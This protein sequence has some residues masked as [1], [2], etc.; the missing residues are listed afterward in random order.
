[1]DL[2]AAMSTGH[3]GSM[4]TTHANAPNEALVRLETLSMMGDTQVPV[5]AIRRQIATAVHLV[6]QI[7]RM[8]DGSRK[9]THI[10]EV[11]PELDEQGRYIVKDIYRFVQRGRT[12]EGRIV[13][14]MVPTGYIPSFMQ[15]IEINRLPFARDKFTP[16]EW[17]I[18]LMMKN[19]EAAA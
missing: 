6:V 3:G 13:G 19:G 18:A 14:E 15:E 5:Q 16:P 7:K 9:V 12:Q 8:S 10:T 2:I 11:V 17:Y 4:G 1:M